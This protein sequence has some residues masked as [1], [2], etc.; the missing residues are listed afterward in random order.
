MHP[1]HFPYFVGQAAD[2]LYYVAP[3]SEWDA[4]LRARGT[5]KSAADATDAAIQ[6]QNRDWQER[7]RARE[8]ASK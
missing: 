6:Q 4:P 5:F 2:G 8:E 3:R 1:R 7:E